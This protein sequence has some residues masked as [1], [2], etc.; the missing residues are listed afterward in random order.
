MVSRLELFT[1]Y[2]RGKDVLDL[3][4]VNHNIELFMLNSCLH[5][6]MKPLCRS[7]TGVDI[8]KEDVKKINSLGYHVICQDVEHLHIRRKFDVVIAGEIIEHLSNPGNMLLSARRHLRKNGILIITTPNAFSFDRSLIALLRE[9]IPTNPEHTVYFTRGT[10]T[11]LLRRYGFKVSEFYYVNEAIED[12][13]KYS[14]RPLLTR[15]FYSFKQLKNH[16]KETMVL[17]CRLS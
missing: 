15:I 9:N 11:E 6:Q 17:I 1:P 3:G 16:Y 5:A 2:I 13:V 7:L 10:V 12:A 8:Q 14:S 4:C